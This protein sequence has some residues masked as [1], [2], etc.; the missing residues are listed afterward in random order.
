M[1]GI[2]NS[3]GHRNQAN[4]GW[5]SKAFVYAF[6]STLSA[7]AAGALLGAVG[8]VVPQ[9]VRLACI[10]LLAICA[11]GVGGFELGVR[12]FRPAQCNRET[13][14]SWMQLGALRWATANGAALGVGV[15]SRIGFWLWYVI[16]VGAL[17]SGKP[18]VGALVYGTYGFVRGAAAIL[19][20]SAV[21]P[22]LGTGFVPWLLPQRP[23][24]RSL[25]ASQLLM[26][27]VAIV[28][29]IGV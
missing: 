15:T 6:A 29:A 8:Q 12:S 1:S 20:V 7:V 23:L 17:L 5:V 3:A 10:T 24:A 13:A 22:R 21:M 11:I 9:T 2:V 19:F 16:P 14:Q 4:R 26:V 25:A 28:V 27:G 18:W